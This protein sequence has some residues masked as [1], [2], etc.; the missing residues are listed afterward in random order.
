MSQNKKY[1][2]LRNAPSIEA[3]MDFFIENVKI[4]IDKL[5]NISEEF[6]KKFP[7]NEKISLVEVSGISASPE[8]VN[9]NTK[10]M[11]LGFRHFSEDS[12]S[13][14]QFKTN[15]YTY[16]RLSPYKGWQDFFSNG[17]Q[18]WEVYKSVIEKYKLLRIGLRYINI[19]EIPKNLEDEQDNFSD[20]FK[21]TLKTQKSIG[22]PLEIKYQFIKNFNDI[23]CKS[24]I[25]FQYIA[26]ENNICK[27]LFDIDII[28]QIGNATVEDSQLKEYLNEMRDAK[29]L[30]FFE[31]LKKKTLE[32]YK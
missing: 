28:R 10:I 13:I 18:N 2:H 3:A 9:S 19:I 4:D 12:K 20:Y 27:Y 25:N 1:P 17:M 21:I 22:I 16:N 11:S 31:V 29:N 32:N 6:R 15:G 14:S 24:I 30:V 23:N 26:E 7:R 8:T 5:Q